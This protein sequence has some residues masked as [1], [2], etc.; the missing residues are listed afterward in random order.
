MRI[1][2]DES[3]TGRLR[4]EFRGH[5]VETVT[6]C[7]WSGLGHHEL[8]KTAARRFD[9]FL[10]TDQN[11]EVKG[12]LRTQRLPSSLWSH[13]EPHNEALRPLRPEA[14]ERLDRLEPRTLARVGS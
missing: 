9:T 8:L 11:M 4:G 6:Q 2:F 1:L 13:E 5:T 12:N 10:S 7:G 14:L 3:L